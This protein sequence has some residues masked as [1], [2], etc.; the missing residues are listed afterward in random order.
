MRFHVRIPSYISVIYAAFLAVAGFTLLIVLSVH[1]GLVI[2]NVPAFVGFILF[3]VAVTTFGF[4]APD[5]GHVSL[6]RVVQFASILIFGALQAA[7]IAGIFSLLWPFLPWGPGRGQSLRM[8]VVRAFSNSGMFIFLMLVTGGLYEYFGGHVPLQH[9]DPRD[10]LLIV[11]LALFMQL[12]NDMFVAVVIGLENYDWR[13]AFGLFAAVVDLAAIPLAVFTAL[14]YNRLEST[15]FL[16]F[17]LV[18]ALI[19]LVVRN[20]ADTRRAL[21]ARVE[22]LIAVNRVGRAVGGSLVTDDLIEMIFH[23][24][25]NLLQF[26]TFMLALY[27]E[28]Q[29]ELDIRL[30]HNPSGR[31]PGRRRQVGEGVF[32]WVVAHNQPVFIRDWE[33][34]TSEFKRIVINIGDTPQTR[35]FI[36]VPVAYRGR[37]L[38]VISVQGYTPDMF[39]DGHLNLMVTFAGQVG[40]AIANAELFSELEQ[41]RNQLEQR[42]Q[43]RTRE[44]EELLVRLQEQ[45]TVLERQSLEDGLTGLYNRRYL[46]SRLI[47]EVKRA[48]RYN[49]AIALAMLDL[50]HFKEVNDRYSHLVG[51]DV[52]RAVAGILR[53]QCRS[54]DIITRFGGEEFLL[55]FPETSRA[56]AL[57]V[58]EK[59]RRAIET[60]NWDKIQPGLKLTASIGLASAPPAYD[61]DTLI[62]AADEQL[63]VAKNSG[64]NCVYG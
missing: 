58:C 7:W 20:F 34:D 9:L 17:L 4:P 33:Q 54:V 5:V 2:G 59:I 36:A 60:H 24:S 23:E 27:D 57:T 30:H 11:V 6:D 13:K 32:G 22:E 50:D 44:K 62:A 38:G 31:Q 47:F 25:Q 42:V 3:G 15:V 37:V 1:A 35:S 51:D 41:N 46:D 48:E 49:R 18:L 14:I 39:D 26:D 40:V 29:H 21:E 10:V 43:E 64:R 56:D 61:A 45:A 52:L 12:L 55:C 28:N 63:Y 8:T 53:T 16:L 19:I